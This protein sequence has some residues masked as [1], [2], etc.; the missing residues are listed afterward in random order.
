MLLSAEQWRK[1]EKV[2][3]IARCVY[4]VSL[5]GS[6]CGRLLKSDSLFIF[7]GT[8]RLNLRRGQR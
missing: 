5:F 7:L 1:D 6:K 4:F 3:E 2:D 8:E